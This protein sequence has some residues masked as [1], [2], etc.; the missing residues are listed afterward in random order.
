MCDRLVVG[1]TTDEL[2]KEYKKKD[3][4]IPPMIEH[5]DSRAMSLWMLLNAELFF[6]EFAAA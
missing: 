3:S 1:V 4:I 6:E 2:I 5:D